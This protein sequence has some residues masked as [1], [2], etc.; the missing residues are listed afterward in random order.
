MAKVERVE[1]RIFPKPPLAPSSQRNYTATFC[2]SEFDYRGY[3]SFHHWLI[4]LS[5]MSSQLTHVVAGV[6]IPCPFKGSTT[7]HCR[8]T[9]HSGYPFTHRGHLGCFITHSFL[10]QILPGVLPRASHQAQ[11]YPQGT[12]MMVE[13]RERPELITIKAPVTFAQGTKT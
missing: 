2:L 1:L 12:Q 10:P 6:R 13:G 7:F 5:A 8:L 11:S 9:P 4:S 3:L